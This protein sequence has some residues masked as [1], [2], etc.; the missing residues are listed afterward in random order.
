AGDLALTTY[1]R[2]TPAAAVGDLAAGLAAFAPR[3]GALLPG[4]LLLLPG[5]ALALWLP[6]DPRWDLWTRLA[7]VLA[8][9]LAFWAMLTLWAGT[10]GVN[11]GGSRVWVVLGAAGIAAVWALARGRR[12][13]RAGMG[14]R[15]A[16][17]AHLAMV[18]VLALAVAGR[19]LN[20]RDLVT[21]NW[22]DSL[23]HTLITRLISEAGGV[24]AT[25]LPYLPV[26]DLHYHFGFHAA[27]AGLTWLAPL[28]ADEAVLLLGQALSALAPL[29]AYALA[30]WLF[31]RRWA[32]VGA[33][34][35][36][37]AVSYMPAY[38]ASW[39]RYTQLAG[40]VMLPLACQ[41]AARALRRDGARYLPAAA[42]LAAGLALVHYRVLLL[43]LA[44]WPLM[45]V[46]Q[47]LGEERRWRALGRV[48]ARIVGRGLVVGGPALAL[49]GPW[50]WRFAAQVFPRVA[51]TYGGWAAQ[52]DGAD[53]LSVGLLGA[54]WM[55]PVLITAGVGLLW[56]LVRRQGAALLLGLWVG[57]WFLAANLRVLGL[58]DIWL[59]DNDAVLISLW[60]PAGALCGYLVADA[61]ALVAARLRARWAHL[62]WGYWRGVVLLTAVVILGVLGTWTHADIVNPVTVLVAEEDL[63]AMDWIREHAPPEALFLV[64]SHGWQ[65]EIRMG[66]DAG[67]WLPMLADRRATM[68]AVLYHHGTAAYR[69]AVRDLSLA[70]EEADSP[71]DP[72][73][74][75]RL[76]AEGVTHVYVGAK[77][78]HLLPRDLDPS[79]H[80]RVIYSDG[81]VRVY[82]FVP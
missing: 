35:V 30:V 81:P 62:P 61:T 69:E 58:R 13:F 59:L 76:A 41:V 8:L 45:A 32:G 21:P 1:Y 33:A 49:I 14:A 3:A 17:P 73:L 5:W 65:G 70:V 43:Y 42:L 57:A 38:Y 27:A 37:G 18:L 9:S 78:G 53:V 40:L 19:T 63:Q 31:R 79:P 22:V 60:L 74:L 68:P 52:G 82:E 67:W 11:A 71:D 55:R 50:A 12:V 80:Y 23:H 26:E 15:G 75:A 20:V 54:Y 48:A 56:G 66:S 51:S 29:A 47:A 10:L 2:Y 25:Y 46:G 34:L 39:G 44:A 24:P 36:A 7:L 64:N 28:R 72:A 77:G 4:L 6:L 16:W